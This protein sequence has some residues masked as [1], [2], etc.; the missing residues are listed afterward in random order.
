MAEDPSK[1]ITGARFRVLEERLEVR[2]RDRHAEEVPH[3]GFPRDLL[4]ELAE[5]FDS[6]SHR[7]PA[8]QKRGPEL[9]G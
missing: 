9:G 7:D 4:L 2:F 6:L 5:L 1:E 8:S 3:E